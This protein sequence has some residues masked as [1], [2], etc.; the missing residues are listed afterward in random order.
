MYTRKGQWPELL[1][2]IH[3]EGVAG[4]DSIRVRMHH[5]NEPEIKPDKPASGSIATVKNPRVIPTVLL[6]LL[7]MVRYGIKFYYTVESVEK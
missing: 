3:Y 5:R 4:Y 1:L 7:E 2:G 6:Y